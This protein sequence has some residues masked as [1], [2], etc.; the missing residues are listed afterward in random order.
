MG[1]KEYEYVT[2]LEILKSMCYLSKFIIKNPQNGNYNFSPSDIS[3]VKNEEEVLDV[4][5]C[6]KIETQMNENKEILANALKELSLKEDSN[7]KEN[8]NGI[9]E[10]VK[11]LEKENKKSKSNVKTLGV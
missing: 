9:K 1:N 10:K 2:Q 11:N 6:K 7:F 8:I 3:F 5:K 4:K